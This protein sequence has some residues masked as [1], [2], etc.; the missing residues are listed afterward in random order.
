MSIRL[1][2]GTH[3]RTKRSDI[4]PRSINCCFSRFP[5]HEV[6]ARGGRNALSAVMTVVSELGEG[7]SSSI[8]EPM[9]VSSRDIAA[10]KE[11]GSGESSSDEG[12]GAGGLVRLGET[13]GDGSA[14]LARGRAGGESLSRATSSRVPSSVAFRPPS[15]PGEVDPIEDDKAME[16]LNVSA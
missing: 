1:A 9:E 6:D 15:L 16:G 4:T 5:E 12:D 3:V 8:S 11:E 2:C 7:K 10:I 13:L 14:L